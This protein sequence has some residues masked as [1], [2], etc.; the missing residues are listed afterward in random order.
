MI[1]TEMDSSDRWQLVDA[2]SRDVENILS[3]RHGLDELLMCHAPNSSREILGAQLELQP[4]APITGVILGRAIEGRFD[5]VRSKRTLGGRY[6]FF[7]LPLT[8]GND[9][10]SDPV[11]SIEFDT[12]WRLRYGTEGDWSTVIQRN[13]MRPWEHRRRLIENLIAAVYQQLPELKGDCA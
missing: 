8:P 6:T 12:N 2:L 7:L 13:P 4:D 9:A 11:F 5:F 3:A 1:F 10:S